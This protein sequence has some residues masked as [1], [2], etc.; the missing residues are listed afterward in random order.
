MFSYEFFRAMIQDIKGRG[1]TFL[2]FDREAPRVNRKFY[3]RHDVDISPACA[4]KMGQIAEQEGLVSNIFF[5]LNA[6]TYNALGQ[7]SLTIIR[8]LRGMGHCVGLH[9]DENLIGA[10]EEKVLHSLRWFNAC[11]E[12]IDMAVSFH[13]PTPSV[14]GRDFDGFASGYGSPFWGADKY[15]SDSRRSGD[16]HPVLMQWLSED[17]SPIQLL[18]HPEWWHP[19]NSAEEVWADLTARRMHELASYMLAN[20]P[21]VF[22]PVIPSR[23]RET[24]I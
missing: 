6:E 19:H 11:C 13:R 10:D 24:Q 7:H 23:N 18:L 1:Y 9:V 8:K 16:F 2:R 12:P 14:L 17:R 4:L 15:L 21:K 3:L 5:Q 22:T 20:F